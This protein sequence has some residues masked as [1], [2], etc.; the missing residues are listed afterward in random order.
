MLRSRSD[1]E[2]LVLARKDNEAFACF[3]ERHVEQVLRYFAHRTREPELAADLMA[4]TFAAA[5]AAVGRFT[6][7]SEPPIAWLFAIAR[8]KLI[9]AQRRGRVAHRARAKL[10]LEPLILEDADLARNEQIG[11]AEDFGLEALLAELSPAERA[12][13]LARVVDERSY[14]DI[15]EELRCSPLVARQRV[16]RGL[17]RLRARL[18]GRAS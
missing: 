15:A 9:D 6:P 10:G 16:S 1:D 17:R 3:Y 7:G 8:R 18:E 2:L 4:E 5:F 13:L 11:A 14:D 12:A